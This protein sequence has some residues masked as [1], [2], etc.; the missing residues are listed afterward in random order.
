MPPEHTGITINSEIIYE[1]KK[2]NN[3][4][5]EYY[6]NSPVKEK[7]IE[8]IPHSFIHHS[9]LVENRINILSPI[10]SPL[11]NFETQSYNEE[12]ILLD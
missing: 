1:D 6:I 7:P 2:I 11:S 9:P 8:E 3:N 10:Q 4:I 12:S 5:N